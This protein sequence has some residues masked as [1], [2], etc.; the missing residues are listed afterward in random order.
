[1]HIMA[2]PAQERGPIQ[3]MAPVGRPGECWLAIMADD[4]RGRRGVRQGR[5]RGEFPRASHAVPR[6]GA[7]VGEEGPPGGTRASPGRPGGA[8]GRHVRPDQALPPLGDLPGSRNR[9]Y[10]R[11]T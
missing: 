9:S 4:D 11:S 2:S 3:R 10:H 1:M 5:R 7:L 8:A 6:G